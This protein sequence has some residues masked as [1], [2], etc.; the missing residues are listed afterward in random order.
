MLHTYTYIC[1]F[2]FRFNAPFLLVAQLAAEALGEVVPEEGKGQDSSASPASLAPAQGVRFPSHR[3]SHTHVS[4]YLHAYMNIFLYSV[5]SG[6]LLP[7]CI[8]TYLP[9]ILSTAKLAQ[10]HRAHPFHLTCLLCSYH[11]L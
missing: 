9:P 2:G 6:C 1:M 11:L 5:L 3:L 10:A 7:P 8:Y 4:I